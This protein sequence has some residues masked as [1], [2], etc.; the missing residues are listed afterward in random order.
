[1]STPHI[2]IARLKAQPGMHEEVKKELLALIEP[3]RKEAGCV[4]YDLHQISPGDFLFYEIWESRE[5]LDKHV[6]TDHFQAFAGKT[7]SLLDGGIDVTEMEMIAEMDT[8]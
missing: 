8:R 7:D 3:T 1:M 6:R 2:I 5:D 4:R